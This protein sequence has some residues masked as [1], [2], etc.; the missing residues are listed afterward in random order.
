M[1]PEGLQ[2]LDTP[3][4]PPAAEVPGILTRERQL[5]PPPDF[6]ATRSLV[7]RLLA[8]RGQFGITRVGAVTRLDRI[9]LP[10]VQV[11]RPLA[12]SNAV[13]QGKGSTLAAAAA[14]ALMEAMETWA[15]ERIAAGRVQIATAAALGGHVTRLLREWVEADVDESWQTV[16]LPWIDGFDLLANSVTPVPLALVDTVYTNPS[17]H[18]RFFPRTTTGL[19]AGAT[20]RQAVVHASLE[21]LERDAR[22][23]AS[24]LTRYFEDHQVDFANSAGPLTRHLLTAI[25][26]AGIVAGAWRV[27]AAH[28]LPIYRCHVMEADEQLELVPLP[29]DGAACDFTADAALARA[30]AEACQSRLTAISGAREDVTR[31]A[32]PASHDRGHLA[33]WRAYLAS[34]ALTG[35]RPGQS[36]ATPVEG[37]RLERVITA[38]RIAGAR[39]VVV[40]PL[41]SDPQLGVHVVRVVAPPLLPSPED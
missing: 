21:I 19:G 39:A 6:D 14:S 30:L 34:F 17:P 31:A 35:E 20:L 15:A 13:T 12:L 33:E 24:R 32:Y 41:H 1:T 40:V 26:C 7:S 10:V 37:D 18:P 38:L 2:R 9:G 27:P 25:Q 23:K 11:V 22:A 28:D 36:A 29:A 5:S 8:R 16:E 3:A 4:P